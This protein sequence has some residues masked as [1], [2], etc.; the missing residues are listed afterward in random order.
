MHPAGKPCW[1][2]GKSGK[3]TFNKAMVTRSGGKKK[4]EVEIK[5]KNENNN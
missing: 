4:I 1:H 3:K 2:S 5:N